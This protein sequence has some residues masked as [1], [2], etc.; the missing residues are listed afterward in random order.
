MQ[1][2][3]KILATVGPASDKVETLSALIKA[4]VNVFRLN[5]SHGSHEY[6]SEV[7]SNIRTAMRETGLIVG[8]MQDISGPK[9]RVGKLKEDF[10][11]ESGDRLDFYYESGIGEQI[12]ANHYRISITE[13][14]ILRMLKSGDFVYLYDG[15]FVP[16]LWPQVK[17]ISKQ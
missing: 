10:Y 13:S 1:K 12:S 11:F 3:T 8:V 4:G 2:R 7:L 14:T 9:I 15:L 16:V 6:H 17:S 5:F